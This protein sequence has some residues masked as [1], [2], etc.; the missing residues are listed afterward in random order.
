MSM[1]IDEDEMDSVP[2]RERPRSRRIPGKFFVISSRSVAKRTT[3]M[4]N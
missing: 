2:T 1:E 3:T 4:T